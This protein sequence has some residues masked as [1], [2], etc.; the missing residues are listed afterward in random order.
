MTDD[1]EAILNDP[2]LDWVDDL[3]AS[4]NALVKAYQSTMLVSR[5][6]GGVVMGAALVI[7]GLIESLR[8]GGDA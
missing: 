2:T 3:V 8:Q 1:T 4:M 6:M 5:Y 7:D